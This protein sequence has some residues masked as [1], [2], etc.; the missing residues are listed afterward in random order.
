[1]DRATAIAT[2]RRAAHRPRLPWFDLQGHRGARGLWPENTLGG[3]ARTLA[4]GVAAVELDCGMS[5]DGVLVVTHDAHLNPECTRDARGTFLASP[6]PLIHALSWSQLQGYD[7]GRL[8]P[9][10]TYA[11]QFPEQQALDGERMPC[12]HDVLQLVRDQGAAHVRV[13]VEVKTF[14]EQPE[15]TAAPERFAQA[16]AQVVADTGMAARIIVQSFDWRILTQV[17]PLLPAVTMAALTDQQPGEDTVRLH[18]APPS[19]WL[20][21]LDPARFGHSLPS[22]VQ[23][24]GASVWSPDYRDLSA[25]AVAAAQAQGLGVVPWTVNDPA[26]M[27]RL[28]DMGVDGLISDRPDTLRSLLQRRA[29]AVPPAA[30]SR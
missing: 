3:F 30:T 26:D 11:A 27:E 5:R 10:S 13:N 29:M 4:L 21:G 12:L 18:S 9:G 14:P 6:A 17:R 1:L 23:A 20:G 28:I 24:I 16:L 2:H 22:L 19:P 7:V 15:L 25:L 8:R